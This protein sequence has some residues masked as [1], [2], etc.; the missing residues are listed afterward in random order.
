MFT[1][2]LQSHAQGYWERGSELVTEIKPGVKYLLQNP[3]STSPHYLSGTTATAYPSE[4]AIYVFEE[5]GVTS[6]QYQ[7]YRLKQAFTG[8]YLEDPDYSGGMVTMT[9]SVTRAFVFTALPGEPIVSTTV[10]DGKE[11]ATQEWIDANPRSKY[12]PMNQNFENVFVFL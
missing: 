11:V 5:A 2:S 7:L 12:E 9:K 8:E 4:E 6:E 10:V 1:L 3:W